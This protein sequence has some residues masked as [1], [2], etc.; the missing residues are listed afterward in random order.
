[1]S[2]YNKEKAIAAQKAF[3]KKTNSPHFAPDNGVCWKCHKNI[4]EP[5]TSINGNGN[6]YTTGVTVE[7]AKTSLVTGCPH[8]NR[9]YCS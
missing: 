7:K 3:A 1:M 6:E 8:C 5:E 2:E 9:S 4:Y